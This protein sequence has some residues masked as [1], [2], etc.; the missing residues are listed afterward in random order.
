MK[1]KKYMVS[2]I[3]P[4]F[5]TE[6]YID[7]CIQSIINQ[8][9]NFNKI[10]II[11]I[12]DG[13]VDNS[14]NICLEYKEKY[15]N[16]VLINKKNSGVSDSR[17]QGIKIASGKYIMILDSDDYISNNCIQ[18]LV[19][20]MENND[21]DISAYYLTNFIES[22]KK[23]ISHFR[24]KSYS[25]GTGIYEVDEYPYIS[26]A[27]VNIIFKN[28]KNNNIYY[29]TTMSIAEDEK[30]NTEI[31]MQRKKI[32][33]VE[34]AIYF[35][36][37]HNSGQVS[38]LKNNPLYCYDSVISYYESIFKKYKDKNGNVEKYIQGLLINALRWRIN[39]DQLLPYFRKDNKYEKSINRLKL[40]INQLDNNIII[41][42]KLMNLY[43]KFYLINM[44]S[45][46]IDVD[47]NSDEFKIITNNEI[48]NH[49][50]SI[51][52]RINRFTVKNNKLY[53]LGFLKSILLLYKKPTLNMLIQKNDKIIKK[54]INTFDS[55][56]KFL[57]T[58][59]DIT[60]IFGFEFEIDITNVTN[61]YFEVKVNQIKLNTK[62]EFSKFT[63]FFPKEK[64]K[65][66]SYIYNK[67]RISYIAKNGF[68]IQNVTPVNF[69]KTNLPRF[70]YTLMNKPSA[71]YYRLLSKI[72]KSKTI[73]LYCDRAGLKDNAY[74]QFKHDIKINDGIKRFYI[75]D[76]KKI[77]KQIFTKNEIKN[78][79]LK[80]SIKA[81]ILQIASTKILTSFSSINEYSQI[82][83]SDFKFYS[84]IKKYELIYLQHG[85][86]YANLIKMYGKEFT[87][88]DKIVISS[89]FEKKN[90]IENYKYNEND[91]ISTGMPRF[92]IENNCK[93]QRKIL[94]APSWRK[95][96]IQDPPVNGYRKPL[97]NIFL[98]SV[99]YNEIN[100]L[101]NNTQLNK[102]LV[103]Y[104]V[105]LDIKLHPIFKC[106][107]DLFK[108]NCSNIH[109]KKEIINELEYSLFITDFSSYQ[110]DFA[111]NKTPIIYF[112]PD[113]KEFDAGLHTYRKLDLPL[114]K[115]FGDVIFNENELSEQIINYIKNNFSVKTKYKNR[116]DK[117]FLKK[118]KITYAIY[119]NLI[120]K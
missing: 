90:L 120:K 116:M 113:K 3:I 30:F 101:I 43:H 39:S 50:K 78:V 64:I 63:P 95:F 83:L 66:R 65:L 109:I 12:N 111:K 68:N 102:Q 60:K 80:S 76:G 7:E 29:D 28:K 108:T 26:Q 34:N 4:V 71:I 5:N 117:F 115:A 19:N 75:Y 57:N 45:Q 24:N 82:K 112:V 89:E 17:N 97:N 8:T 105:E 25:S 46:K 16:I 119:K 85:L 69:I 94:F 58:N 11:L 20:F 107:N 54:K 47:I 106:Y 2:V 32:G 93:K 92:E 42:N 104:N 51:T 86:L 87:E 35:Y 44:K 31:I 103:K 67:K 6:N 118:E 10:Q 41:N 15:K 84:D 73:W 110:F 91:L 36:R 72:Y 52:I 114:E 37:K 98:S 13:S 81:I 99:F 96:L 70:I 38:K 74:Y 23:F 14:Y 49:S 100:K 59:M 79:V 1:E 48:L 33:F 9:Y 21:V 55:N 77:N 18:E 61:I 27:T 22:T 88:I 56:W 62:F 53:I 40:L